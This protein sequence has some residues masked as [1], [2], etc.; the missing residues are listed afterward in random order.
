MSMV[1]LTNK[2]YAID[3]LGAFSFKNNGIRQARRGNALSSK[4]AVT[5]ALGFEWNQE[6][7]SLGSR[8]WG[9]KMGVAIARELDD[10]RCAPPLASQPIQ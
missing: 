10:R 4:L 2:S 3:F 1:F 5:F 6:H 7:L 9:S 8:C